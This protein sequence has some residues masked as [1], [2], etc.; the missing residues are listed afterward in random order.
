MYFK[1]IKGGKYDDAGMPDSGTYIKKANQSSYNCK[2][3]AS[4]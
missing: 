2:Q 1:G 4:I 3:E